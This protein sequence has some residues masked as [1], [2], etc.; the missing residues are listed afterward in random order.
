MKKF[1]EL[2]VVDQSNILFFESRFVRLSEPGLLISPWT[3]E[4]SLLPPDVSIVDA[5][6]LSGSKIIEQANAC[7][8]LNVFLWGASSAMFGLPLLPRLFNAA[9]L[10]PDLT[11]YFSVGNPSVCLDEDYSYLRSLV[12]PTI[13]AAIYKG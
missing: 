1:V 4:I 10:F 11:S 8:S 12:Q 9:D 6:G 7:A 3:E 2:K 5:V 13:P